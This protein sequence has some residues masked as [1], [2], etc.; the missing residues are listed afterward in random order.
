MHT[1]QHLGTAREGCRTLAVHSSLKPASCHIIVC[2]LCSFSSHA[3][4]LC[5]FTED[6]LLFILLS[7][8]ICLQPLC[9]PNGQVPVWHRAP[10]TKHLTG[11]WL[12]LT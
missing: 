2:N 4:L 7:L 6:V 10:E 5:G 8:L 11:W 12:N 9:M 1:R 3:Q